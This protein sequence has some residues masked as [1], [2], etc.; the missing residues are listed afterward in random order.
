MKSGIIQVIGAIAILLI[1]IAMGSAWK[2]KAPGLR[3]ELEARDNTIAEMQ[4]TIQNLEARAPKQPG[5]GGYS[6]STSRAQVEA[7][8]QHRLAE[9]A[10]L[11]SNATLLVGALAAAREA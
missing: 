7:E 4:A 2:S 1:G 8:I 11:Q 5:S 3:Q 10:R 6:S 9:A